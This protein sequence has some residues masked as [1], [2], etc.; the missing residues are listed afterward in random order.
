VARGVRCVGGGILWLRRVL[1]DHAGAVRYDL[2]QLGLRLEDLGTERLTWADLLALV[3]HAE[4]STAI[5]KALD[6][7][8]MQT[9]EVDMLR[10]I[11]YSLRKLHHLWSGGSVWDQPKPILWPWEEEEEARRNGTI[12]GTPVTIDEAAARL[13]WADVEGVANAG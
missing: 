1:A 12:R 11:E 13:G 5:R 8:W 9:P 6:P 2:L 7:R 4:P 10:S 3:D